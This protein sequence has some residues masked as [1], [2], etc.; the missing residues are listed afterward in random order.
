MHRQIRGRYRT[1]TKFG[2]PCAISVLVALFSTQLVSQELSIKPRIEKEFQIFDGEVS[3][4][5]VAPSGKQVLIGGSNGSIE[6]RNTEE[7]ELRLVINDAHSCEINSIKFVDDVDILSAGSDGHIN[8]W[9]LM[10]GRHLRHVVSAE[11]PIRR[12]TVIDKNRI[13]YVANQK[14]ILLGDDLPDGFNDDITLS[15]ASY[16]DDNKM[17]FAIG[18]DQRSVKIHDLK[19]SRLRKRIKLPKNLD[20]FHGSTPHNVQDICFDENGEKLG[21]LCEFKGRI[22]VALVD[23]ADETIQKTI[24]LSNMGPMIQLHIV[25]DADVLIGIGRDI[26]FWKM[27]TGDE[28]KRISGKTSDL[29]QPSAYF[30]CANFFKSSSGKHKGFV[31][32]KDGKLLV[33][34]L[35]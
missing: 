14:L 32:T 25:P 22:W 19:S 2:E 15:F 27:E 10:S 12:L 21:V 4:I 23:V 20:S 18:G 33:I 28:I 8:R 1:S 24:E 11:H 35:D 26:V 34:A 7:M 17:L 5:A 29:G 3:A 6:I 13:A 31:G 9:S 16:V 30:L